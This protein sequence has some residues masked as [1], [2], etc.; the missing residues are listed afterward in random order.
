MNFLTLR[1]IVTGTQLMVRHQ[2]YRLVETRRVLGRHAVVPRLPIH[3][4]RHRE[5]G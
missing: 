3:K 5:L 1:G 4:S 2:P